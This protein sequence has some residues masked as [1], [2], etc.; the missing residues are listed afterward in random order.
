ML[1]TTLFINYFKLCYKI[2]KAQF[3]LMYKN[4]QFL[5][6]CGILKTFLNMHFCYYT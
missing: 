1:K 6:A 2:F 4:R 5:P 3:L